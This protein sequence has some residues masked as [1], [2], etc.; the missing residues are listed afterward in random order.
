MIQGLLNE[1]SG[2]TENRY[3]GTVSALRGLLFEVHGLDG[4]LSTGNQCLVYP[5]I[6]SP[7]VAEVVGFNNNNA[8]MMAYQPLLGVGPGCRVEKT[9]ERL[10]VCPDHTWLGRVINGFAQPIDGGPA[11]PYG[12][13]TMP[14]MAP[15]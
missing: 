1:I 7:I 13:T 14:V 8:Q 5:A 2:L 4:Y 10:S 9:R 15:P 11:L 3:Y 6:G 12:S